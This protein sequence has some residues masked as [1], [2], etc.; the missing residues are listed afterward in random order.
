MKKVFIVLFLGLLLMFNQL[1]Y[2]EQNCN[3]DLNVIITGVPYCKSTGAESITTKKPDS[4]DNA[5]EPE[6]NSTTID[7]PIIY[8][9][10][11]MNNSLRNP[12]IRQNYNNN[13]SPQMVPNNPSDSRPLEIP[14]SSNSEYY[15]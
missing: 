11:L 15:Y 1:A 5:F 3:P 6:N 12:I 14:G 7:R 2:A 13:L 4:I 8:Y 10:P 9:S